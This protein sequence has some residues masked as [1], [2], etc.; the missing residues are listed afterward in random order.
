MPRKGK[1]SAHAH[2]S[3]EKSIGDLESIR[4]TLDAGLFRVW[5]QEHQT[6]LYLCDVLHEQLR[7]VRDELRLRM[8]N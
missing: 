1:P 8:M 5:P 3:V 6:T 4:A 7:F 2:A